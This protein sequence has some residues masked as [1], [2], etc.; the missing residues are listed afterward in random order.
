MQKAKGSYHIYS[1]PGKTVT[2]VPEFVVEDLPSAKLQPTSLCLQ[3]RTCPWAE[4]TDDFCL[5]HL[6]TLG[7]RITRRD[8]YGQRQDYGDVWNRWQHGNDK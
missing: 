6:A 2:L 1:I 8:K 4:H 7:K 5:E 3:R